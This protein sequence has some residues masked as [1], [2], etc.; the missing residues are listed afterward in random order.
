MFI[1]I[2]ATIRCDT[3]AARDLLLQMLYDG[4][5]LAH[6]GSL[7]LV[8][9]LHQRRWDRLGI[10]VPFAAAFSCTPDAIVL[11]CCVN[12][13]ARSFPLHQLLQA[14]PQHFILLFKL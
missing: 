13:F 5:Q 9:D 7:A 8:D 1:Y 4:T 10:T 14:S 6:Y 3:G 12:K 2:A 11:H